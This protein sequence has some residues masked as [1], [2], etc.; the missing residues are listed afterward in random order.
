MCCPFTCLK[1]GYRPDKAV[2]CPKKES[3]SIVIYALTYPEQTG[4]GKRFNG[5][6]SDEKD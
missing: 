4:T 1:A 6:L 5:S 3:L 2:K